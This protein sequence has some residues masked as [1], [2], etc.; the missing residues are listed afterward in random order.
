MVGCEL[1]RE[2][3]FGST[4]NSQKTSCSGRADGGRMAQSLSTTCVSEFLFVLLPISSHS[5]LPG[6]ASNLIF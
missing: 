5:S 4:S 2:W 1:H 3:S 6:V